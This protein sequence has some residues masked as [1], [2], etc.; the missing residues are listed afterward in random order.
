MTHP[1]V[2]RSVVLVSSCCKQLGG[3]V[4]HA[5]QAKY[6]EA[7]VYGAQCQP[8]LI[9]ALG[10]ALDL[11]AV[12]AVAH[13]ILLTGSVS[14]VHPDWYSQ[15]IHHPDLPTDPARDA[16]TLPLI[17]AALARGI[18][19]FAIC[20]GAQEVNVALGGSLFQAVHEQP[21]RIDHREKTN[22]PISE[23]YAAAHWVALAPGGKLAQIVH[24]LTS[25]RGV[26]RMDDAEVIDAE[27]AMDEI[28][29]VNSL[30]GQA[31]DVLAPGL[32]VEAVADDGVIE[33]FSI[34]GHAGFALA[35]Q[36]HPE[37]QVTTNRVSMA[38][39][40]AFGQAC[41]EYQRSLLR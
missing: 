7:L 20:R 40:G 8:L 18:P 21:G 2:A 29:A 33:A 15:A 10:P 6:A 14:N 38:L 17:K 34:A 25:R 5:T 31:V 3:A 11:D 37:W 19:L 23:Q 32:C 35:V 28:I 4:Y 39:F 12:L 9:P 27:S 24:G 13:G 36:W 22:I 41:R 1:S 30:H 26:Y 16:T